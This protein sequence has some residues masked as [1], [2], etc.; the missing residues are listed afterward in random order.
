MKN[1]NWDT[2]SNTA[3]SDLWNC[4]V[5]LELL[6]LSVL[7]VAGKLANAEETVRL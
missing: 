5:G 3:V 2:V 7:T 1:L 6:V 4:I